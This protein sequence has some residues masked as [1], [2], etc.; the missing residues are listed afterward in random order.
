[1][2]TRE[3]KTT[4]KIKGASF[5]G[6]GSLCDEDGEV[7]DLMKNLKLIFADDTF[8]ISITR[9]SK[10]NLEVEDFEGVEE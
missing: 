7:I 4:Y 8:D 9:S 5:M 3:Q 2:I 1:M 6:N 10:D